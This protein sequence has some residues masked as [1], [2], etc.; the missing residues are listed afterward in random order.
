MSPVITSRW[1]PFDEE[2][3]LSCWIVAW[4]FVSLKRQFMQPTDLSIR[5]NKIKESL[6]VCYKVGRIKVFQ[7]VIISILMCER[8]DGV[9]R[10]AYSWA[11]C[12]SEMM[13]STCD[14]KTDLLKRPGRTA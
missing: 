7:T 2:D 10:G 6:V 9:L 14:A 8:K 5:P 13:L 11:I 4:R 3:F 1:A 12:S